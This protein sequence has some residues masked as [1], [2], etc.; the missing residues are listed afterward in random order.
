M[1]AGR[2]RAGGVVSCT[3]TVKLPV[4][5][6]PWASVAEQ[7]TVVEP[8]GKTS[9]ELASHVTGTAPS[10][11]SRAV[12]ENETAAPFGPVASAT[13]LGRVSTGGGGFPA[14]TGELP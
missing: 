11:T 12:A 4:A 1:S 9:P 2:L 7:L 6:F 10:T 8:S 3:F 13:G 14:G 5:V